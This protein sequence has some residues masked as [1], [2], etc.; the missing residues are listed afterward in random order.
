MP[1][2]DFIALL[3]QLGHEFKRRGMR[4]HVESLRQFYVRVLA[5]ERTLRSM[6][7]SPWGV[8]LVLEWLFTFRIP[9]FDQR[10]PQLSGT[11]ICPKC[12]AGAGGASS[13][14]GHHVRCVFP[15]G[16]LIECK[17]GARWLVDDSNAEAAR[18][19]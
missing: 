6:R 7:H 9:P 14:I 3:V 11:A 2:L 16:H 18:A 5:P 17:C 12:S 1:D 8:A 13:G 19:H 4:S 15:G 10:Y